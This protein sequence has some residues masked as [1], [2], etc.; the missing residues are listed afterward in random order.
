MQCEFLLTCGF[1]EKTNKFEPFMV[2]MI[3]LMY[4]ENNKY[5]CSRYRLHNYL[6]EQEIPDDL[7]PS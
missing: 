5:D 4:C 3:K 1:M 6:P 2:T 7:W